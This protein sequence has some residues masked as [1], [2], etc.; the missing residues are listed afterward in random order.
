MQH[1]RSNL[2]VDER[3]ALRHRVGSPPR[4]FGRRGR[5]AE[6]LVVAPRGS[7]RRIPPSMPLPAVGIRP[8]SSSSSSSSSASSEPRE[9]CRAGP[10]TSGSKASGERSPRR[11]RS[12]SFSEKH[13]PTSRISRMPRL[14]C[15]IAWKAM[16]H[17]W[18]V[19][20]Q[21]SSRLIVHAGSGVSLLAVGPMVSLP[22]LRASAGGKASPVARRLSARGSAHAPQA[23]GQR[24]HDCDRASAGRPTSRA[25]EEKPRRSGGPTG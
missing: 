14:R 9:G 2:G 24:P 12:V 18:K 1:P 20:A 7:P 11:S 25:R 22:C 19:A 13:A 15:E 23:H 5:R 16:A 8:S 17:G 6:V 10:S 4:A 21:V 3:L